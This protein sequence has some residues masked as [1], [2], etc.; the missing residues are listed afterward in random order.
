MY[1][2]YDTE[3]LITETKGHQK[4]VQIYYDETIVEIHEGKLSYFGEEYAQDKWFYKSK[5]YSLMAYEFIFGC[6]GNF[7]M[8]LQAAR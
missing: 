7:D 3:K 2:G 4:C 1:C 6:H 5:G 8:E